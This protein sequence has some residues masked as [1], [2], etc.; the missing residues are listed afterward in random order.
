MPITRTDRKFQLDTVSAELQAGG[1][2]NSFRS[3]VDV[4]NSDIYIYIYG[5]P[6]QY[7]G[8]VASCI[9]T[10]DIYSVF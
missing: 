2:A 10:I 9:K 4:L 5:T 3:V 7:P 1:R 8:V 6:P